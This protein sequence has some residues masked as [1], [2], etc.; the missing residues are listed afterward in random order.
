MNEI[1]VMKVQLRDG[2]SIL[3][4]WRQELERIPVPGEFLDIDTSRKQFLGGYR[5]EAMVSKIETNPRSESQTVI[6]QAKVRKVGDGRTVILLNRNYIPETLTQ[7]VEDRL[8]SLLGLPA[9]MW[10]RSSKNRAILNIHSPEKLSGKKLKELENQ[11]ARLLLGA[12]PL[13][14]CI[15]EY[16]V[17]AN[18]CH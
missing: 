15:L 9:F 12:S 5:P 6:L 2:D 17:A 3:D 14:A 10:E 13:T 16:S 4:S 8:R 11:I 7:E 18:A 1:Q